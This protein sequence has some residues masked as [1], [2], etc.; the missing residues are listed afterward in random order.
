MFNAVAFP[1]RV[2]LLWLLIAIVEA[3]HG[4]LRS[5]FLVP[6]IGTKGAHLFGVVFGSLLIL[7][8]ALLGSDWLAAVTRRQQLFA[9]LCW[10]L[11]MLAFEL[12][13]GRLLGLG[14]DRLVADYD[15]SRGGLMLIG[16]LVLGLA[17][18]LAARLQAPRSPS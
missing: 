16:M 14:W 5:L 15:L 11:L 3:I 13:L 17:P 1:I 7:V 10:V 9:G 6:M 18:W 2:F 12:G 8:I 4:T